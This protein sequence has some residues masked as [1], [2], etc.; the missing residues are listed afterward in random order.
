MKI[1][2]THE[3]CQY[4]DNCVHNLVLVSIK[5]TKR[6]KNNYFFL[7]RMSRLRWKLKRQGCKVQTRKLVKRK[8]GWWKESLNVYSKTRS[9]RDQVKYLSGIMPA[10]LILVAESKIL[11]DHCWIR[12]FMQVFPNLTTKQRGENG[13]GKWHYVRNHFTIKVSSLNLRWNTTNPSK[14]LK[15]RFDES[16]RPLSTVLKKSFVFVWR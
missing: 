1:G 4:I 6:K 11:H 5:G 14:L 9:Q 15:L 16:T 2:P 8:N 3:D 7:T 10:L 12:I 13:W